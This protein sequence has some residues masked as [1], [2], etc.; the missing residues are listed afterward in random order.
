MS[1]VPSSLPELQYT[2]ALK[3]LYPSVFMYAIAG[4]GKTYAFESVVDLNPLVIATE[5]GNTKGMSTLAHLHI[6]CILVNSTEEMVAVLAEMKAT[7]KPGEAYYRGAGPFGLVGVDSFTGIGTFLEVSSRKMKG[8]DTIWGDVTAGGKKDPRSAYP[9]IAEKGRQLYASILGL[10][11]PTV[12]T[13]REQLFTEGE[14][15]SAITYATPEL[16]GQK[17]PKELPGEPEATVRLR[18]INGVRTMVT[19]NEGNVIARVRC[20][21]GL[22]PPQHSVPN[23]GALIRLMQGDADALRDLTPQ[24]AQVQKTPQQIA[25]EQSAL[26]RAQ[27]AG[28]A[29]VAQPAPSTK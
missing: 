8:W 1:I 29:Y 5:K 4:A 26:Q 18:M 16:P 19:M 22:R 7:S 21:K 10:P 11:V 3:R 17:L 27:P 25:A 20:K 2:D 15:Q 6:A 13:C 23:L 24:Q 14:G 28:A 12:V 9:Y